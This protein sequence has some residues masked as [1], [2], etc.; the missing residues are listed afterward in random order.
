MV[1][2][3]TR[4]SL[5]EAEWYLKAEIT[6]FL[7]QTARQAHATPR[8][9]MLKVKQGFTKINEQQNW[10]HREKINSTSNCFQNKNT[11]LKNINKVEAEPWTAATSADW[12]SN[13]RQDTDCTSSASPLSGASYL[14]AVEWAI[15]MTPWHGQSVNQFLFYM[16]KPKLKIKWKLAKELEL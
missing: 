8:L 7:E 12:Q 16:V 5:R 2:G 10:E 1:S 6:I 4:Q 14:W 3:A 15:H 11:P 9:K 13:N